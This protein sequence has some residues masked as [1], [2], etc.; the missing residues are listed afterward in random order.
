MKFTFEFT[1]AEIN[2]SANIWNV[3]INGVARKILLA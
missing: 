2:T 3:V 1:E